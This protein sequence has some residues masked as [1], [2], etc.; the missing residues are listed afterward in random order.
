MVPLGGHFRFFFFEKRGGIKPVVLCVGPAPVVSLAQADAS[1][2]AY[3]RRS[4]ATCVQRPVRVRSLGPIDALVGTSP[5]L[6]LDF[7]C[8]KKLFFT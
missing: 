4:Q 2:C 7:A 5:A 3:V 1:V 8:D 6:G